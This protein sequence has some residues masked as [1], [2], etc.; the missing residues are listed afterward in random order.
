MLME[1][2]ELTVAFVDK[3]GYLGILIMMTLESTFVP[4]P[5]ELVMPQAGYLAASGKMDIWIAILMATVGSIL[6]ALINYGLAYWLGRPFF[7]KYGKYILCPPH[8]FDKM[9]KFF[10]RHGEVGTFTGRMVIGVRHFISFP[11]GLARMNLARFC[12]YTGLGAGLWAA[13]LA[14]IGF[15]AGKNKDLLHTYYHEAAGILFVFC[16]LVIAVYTVVYRRRHRR[17]E[18]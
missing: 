17:A 15:M 2:F 4:L 8:K 1:L 13:V 5:S 12:L 7:L 6:G 10:L 16:L 9:E 11:A 3:A 14:W 18:G